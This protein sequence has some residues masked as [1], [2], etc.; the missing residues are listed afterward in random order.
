[1]TQHKV[2]VIGAGPGDPSF[3]TEQAVQG[4]AQAD[5]VFAAKRHAGLAAPEKYCPLEPFGESVRE[6][7]RRWKLGERLA[8][9]VSGD[10]GLFSLLPML[11]RT[12]GNENVDVVPGISA[13]QAMYGAL[14]ESWQGACILSGHGRPLSPGALLFDVERHFSTAIFCDSLHSPGWICDALLRGGLAQ[15]DVAVGEMLGYREERIT[16]GSP[17]AIR[18]GRYHPLCM[19]RIQNPG[20]RAALP[21]S[22]LPDEDFIRGKTPM[23]KREVRALIVGAL[24]LACDAVVWDIGAGTGS[25][26]VACA[27]Q[28]PLGEVYAVEQSES[29]CSLIEQNAEKLHAWNV[30]PVTGTAPEALQALPAP[31]HIFLGGSGG[32]AA[33][34]LRYIETLPAPFRLAATAVTMESAGLFTAPRKG[35]ANVTLSHIAVTRIEPVGGVHMFRA[36]NP[37]FLLSA[38]WKGQSE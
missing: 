16:R 36:Q 2:M 14:G 5:R 13:L 35:W 31:T 27:L 29:A 32:R 19:V 23:T 7:E 22:D 21:L 6:V 33:E 15:A 12:L 3:L 28:C 20:W 30:R 11:K 38:D 24:H 26:S 10:P 25:V 4:L 37:V 1:M 8:V 17:A 34:I 9:L 18:K